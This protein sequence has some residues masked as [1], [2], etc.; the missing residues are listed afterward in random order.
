MEKILKL[1]AARMGKLP[2]DIEAD[3]KKLAPDL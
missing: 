2:E 1:K 3:F